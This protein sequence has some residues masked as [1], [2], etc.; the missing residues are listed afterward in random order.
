MMLE[1]R[2][3][4]LYWRGKFYTLQKDYEELLKDYKQLKIDYEELKE[5][6]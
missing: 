6:V 2:F 1:E 3:N 5:D 4:Y